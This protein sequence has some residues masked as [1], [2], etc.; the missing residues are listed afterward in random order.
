L[1]RADQ[2]QLDLQERLTFQASDLLPTSP[3]TKSQ[4]STGA[5][6]VKSLCQAIVEYSDNTAA[7]LLLTH[8][9]GPA[10]VTQFFRDIGDN[11]SRLDRM[12]MALN[13]NIPGDERDTTTPRAMAE[14]LRQLI[15]EPNRL[16]KPSRGL[17]VQWMRNEQNAKNRIRAAV[18]TSWT[19]ANKPG[20]SFEGAAN[21]IAV[22]WSPAGDPFLVTIYIDT[23]KKEKTR[24]AVTA[25]KD[26]ADLA[27][28]A[29]L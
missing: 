17:L 24:T 9:G 13:A 15:L 14:N 23:R 22:L 29:V 6:T 27:L 5:M 11:T 8:V 28:K 25:I 20:T 18:P 7:N 1:Q 12:E 26:I 10:A 21:D 3:I 4:A 19:V 2:G 16:S